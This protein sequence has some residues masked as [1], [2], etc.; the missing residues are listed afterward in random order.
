MTEK[1]RDEILLELK[2][3]INVVEDNMKEMKNDI[4]EMREDVT[5][6]QG[7]IGNLNVQMAEV[8]TEL[9]SMSG[10]VATIEV[11]HGEKIQALFDIIEEPL[12][13][14]LAVEA[15]VKSHK[16]YL[17]EHDIRIRTLESKIS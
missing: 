1:E 14:S 9:S 13:K 15:E 16:D 2:D 17:N 10:S 8:K 6:M 3:K 4:N 7:N 11:V 5:V 12:K